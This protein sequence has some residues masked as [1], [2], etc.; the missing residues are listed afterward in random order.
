MWPSGTVAGCYSLAAAADPLDMQAQAR[1]EAAS[2][3]LQLLLLAT[4][5]VAGSLQIHHHVHH[6]QPWRAF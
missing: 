3:P 1:F 4:A 5:A 2:S 6:H